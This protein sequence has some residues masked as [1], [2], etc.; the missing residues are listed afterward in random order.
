MKEEG[1]IFNI[2]SWSMMCIAPYHFLHSLIGMG[3]LYED[4]SVTVT[5]TFDPLKL[6]ERV[7]I[8]SE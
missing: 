1:P 6:L 8:Y 3:L 7:R 2:L 5:D 4:D